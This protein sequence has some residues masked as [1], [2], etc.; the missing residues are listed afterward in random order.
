MDLSGQRRSSNVEDRRSSFG[1]RGMRV[2]GGLSIGA[3]IL[4]VIVSR[5]IGVDPGALLQGGE[6]SAPYDTQ[7]PS[8]PIDDEGSDFVRAVLGSTE[9]A[10]T[11]V[12]AQS[13]Q[14]YRAPRLV[15]FREAVSSA[16]GMESA[17]TGPFYCPGDQKVYLDLSFF[18]QLSRRFGAPGDMAAAYVIGHEVGHHVQHL[19]GVDQQIRASQRQAGRAAQNALQVRMELQADC[20]AG[21]WAHHAN[22]KAKIIE[23]G[24]IEE[25][26][27]AA[28]AI[29]DD[30]LTKG[31][32]SPDNFTHGTSAERAR[33]FQTG[34]QAGKPEACDTLTN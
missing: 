26:I 30:T 14:R 13:N 12:F 2:G 7:A 18:D 32:V 21:V 20:F 10:W 22:K 6:P 23:P 5:L 17:A 4:V 29:G 33:W 31:R 1:G 15:L 8:Q 28:K 24:D 16:C 25:A 27:G 3:V 19:T 11:D 9:D 34:Y